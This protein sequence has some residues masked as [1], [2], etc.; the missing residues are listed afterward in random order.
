VR[1]IL[2]NSACCASVLPPSV[3]IVFSLINQRRLRIQLVGKLE[4]THVDILAAK[5]LGQV[6]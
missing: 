4:Q 1:T 2:S 6:P 5:D 3:K